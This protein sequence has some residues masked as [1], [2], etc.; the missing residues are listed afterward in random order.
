MIHL[1]MFGRML[2]FGKHL[3]KN[4]GAPSC[5]LELLESY[6]NGYAGLLGLHLPPLVNPCLIVKMQPA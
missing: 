1:S 2:E 3:W 5:Y 6:K 4:G